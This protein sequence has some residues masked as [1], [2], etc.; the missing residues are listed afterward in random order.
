[1]ATWLPSP[2]QLDE[3]EYDDDEEDEKLS[4]EED[5]RVIKELIDLIKK[6]GGIEEL[7]KQ[8][9]LSKEGSS[10]QTNQLT[11]QSPISK[12]LY[13]RVLSKTLKN[14]P[15]SRKNSYVSSRNSRGPQ[16]E[17]LSTTVE[18]TSTRSETPRGKLSYTTISRNRPAASKTTEDED[19]DGSDEDG[20]DEDDD[21]G[22]S[23]NTTEKSRIEYVDIRRNRNRGSTTAKPED[24]KV[25]NRNQILGED[26]ETNDESDDETD[27]E[28]EET[29]NTNSSKK[30]VY[31]PQ[32]VNIRRSRPSTTEEPEA[33]KYVQLRRGTTESTEATTESSSDRTT[34]KYKF[35]RR[36][37]TSTEEPEE[38]SSTA[39][40]QTTSSASA[41]TS[42]DNISTKKYLNFRRGPTT[43]LFSSVSDNTNSSFSSEMPTSKVTETTTPTPRTTEELG[44]TSQTSTTLTSDTQQEI[45]K[46]TFNNIPTLLE[47]ISSVKDNLNQKKTY[48]IENTTDT[49]SSEYHKI[50]VEMSRNQSKDHSFS[51]QD[52]FLNR[53]V[54]Q[55]LQNRLLNHRRQRFNSNI[56]TRQEDKSPDYFPQKRRIST[57]E[58]YV[59]EN[60]SYRPSELA[61]LSSL[62]AADFSRVSDLDL[63]RATNR[64]RRP[65]VTSTISEEASEINTTPSTR[66]LDSASS[67]GRRRKLIRGKPDPTKSDDENTSTTKRIRGFSSR[68]T[69]EPSTTESIFSSSAAF[70]LLSRNRK[71]IRRLKTSTPIPS[72]T[73]KV[74]DDLNDD[75]DFQENRVEDENDDEDPVIE[76]EENIKLSE[77]NIRENSAINSFGPDPKL[78]RELVGSG[79]SYLPEKPVTD[80][81]LSTSSYNVEMS[82][83]DEFSSLIPTEPTIRAEEEFESEQSFGRKRK[84]IRKLRPISQFNRI[85]DNK[86]TV[87]PKIIEARNRFKDDKETLSTE[88][89]LPNTQRLSLYSRRPNI[90]KSTDDENSS[91]ENVISSS[92]A[93]DEELNDYSDKDD[94]N[95]NDHPENHDSVS[96]T[97]FISS[98][99][100]ELNF[101]KYNRYRRPNEQPNSIRTKSTTIIETEENS[102]NE[103]RITSPE[104]VSSTP[105]Y[106]DIKMTSQEIDDPDT[107]N[108][109]STSEYAEVEDITTEYSIIMNTTEY[110]VP[111]VTETYTIEILPTEF[112]TIASDSETYMTPEIDTERDEEIRINETI[113]ESNK[114]STSASLYEITTSGAIVTNDIDNTFVNETFS[115]SIGP[116]TLKDGFETPEVSTEN[117]DQTYFETTIIPDTT[118]EDILPS[119]KIVGDISSSSTIGSTTQQHRTITLRPI[120]ARPKFVPPRLKD[121]SIG[122]TTESVAKPSKAYGGNRLKLTTADDSSINDSSDPDTVPEKNTESRSKL[123]PKYSTTR[124]IE[125]DDGDDEEEESNIQEPTEDSLLGNKYKK[126][127]NSALRTTENVKNPEVTEDSDIESSSAKSINIFL[128]K[129]STT[130][131]LNSEFDDGDDEVEEEISIQEPT[132]DSIL[133]N[134]YKKGYNSALRTTDNVKNPE[135]T[136]DSHFGRSSTKSINRFLYKYSTTENLNSESDD[137][138]DEESNVQ[139]PSGDRDEEIIEGIEETIPQVSDS[140]PKSR[141]PNTPAFAKKNTIRLSNKPFFSKPSTENSKIEE[142]LKDIDTEA[143]KN[144]NKSC[145]QKIG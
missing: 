12:S 49:S 96:T 133:V 63:A 61:D 65:T 60:R 134:K 73:H 31:T 8:L 29:D 109:L 118:T 62:T 33:S 1:M 93:S 112:V 106:T 114:A 48:N 34:S 95:S 142:S 46:E 44:S 40:Y 32:Y 79:K 135:V 138:D 14:T 90:L 55:L 59:E 54:V 119:E 21:K 85:E 7:E 26:D 45:K 17:G 74:E 87:K 43:E 36:G 15:P 110:E 35:I 145:S 52:H 144:R 69:R 19:E 124:E 20:S 98:K 41:A 3:Y 137:D 70:N 27:D 143:I 117:S 53:H 72:S 6:A 39:R 132:E 71:V 121:L 80:Q 122:Q 11:T 30:S 16:S 105:V 136:E 125:S 75:S 120:G 123:S 24:K 82:D 18:K 116:T 28:E 57:T 127:Y 51:I 78:R 89:R 64:R 58:K 68:S 76:E 140:A 108:E 5:P 111:N 97:E 129:Y 42:D 77:S 92:S 141:K 10:S 2:G 56:P 115:D 25:F 91:T 67:F 84:I 101:K 22:K 100:T 104:V 47:S 99:Y 38:E 13:E 131:N 86:E 139:D 103:N 37:S 81:K 128:Y 113:V 66:K 88:K 23:R 126:G 107:N 9:K 94:H 83:V 4:K 50:P 130:E 102:P